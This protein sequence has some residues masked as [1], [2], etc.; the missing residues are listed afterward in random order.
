MM[1]TPTPEPNTVRVARP[2]AES[3]PAPQAP[4]PMGL[5]QRV[6]NLVAVTV[7]VL[8]LVAAI[9]F[10]WGRGFSWVDLGLLLG[11][12]AVTAVGIT[13]GFHRLFTHR[14]F[15]TNRVVQFALGALGSMAV[16]GPLLKWVA[17]HRRHH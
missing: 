8:G 10:L 13:V 16:Q 14:S 9:V 1:V 7:P 11:M 4:Q 6:A 15:E 5:G 2:P 3:S 17:F 12:Y